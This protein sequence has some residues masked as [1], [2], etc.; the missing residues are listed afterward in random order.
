[1]PKPRAPDPPEDRHRL[2]RRGCAG[3]SP[4]RLAEEPE[5]SE[6]TIR[7]GVRQ[8]DLNEGLCADGLTTTARGTCAA[9]AGDPVAARRTGDS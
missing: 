9:T 8:A 6:R 4:A 7:R 5:L 3:H 1:M 2:V